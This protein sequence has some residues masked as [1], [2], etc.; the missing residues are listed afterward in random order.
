MAD[1]VIVTLDGPAGVGKS[2]LARMLA[3]RL[4]MA[5]LDT[6][7]MYRA[8]AFLLGEGSW[9]WPEERL[10]GRLGGMS[11][12]LRG[13]GRDSQL[14]VGQSPLLDKD[15]RTETV[16]MWASNVATL[17]VVR[18]YL[19]KAQQD[20][21]HSTSL[22]AEGR[23]MGTVV[24]PKARHKFFLDADSGE[25]AWRRFLQLKE[26]G[27]P[28]DLDDLARQIAARDKQDRTRAEAPLRPAR[29]AVIIDTTRLTLAQVFE[30]LLEAIE[31]KG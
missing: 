16:G 11:F 15:I 10:A 13:A 1:P 20:L 23:D 19:K 17:P 27:R 22:V 30:R 7:A 29:D 28:A 4:G 21:A 3:E 8:A 18:A 24:F 6:G 25:R 12:S 14:W 9:N 31:R 2:T 5:Y 26:M